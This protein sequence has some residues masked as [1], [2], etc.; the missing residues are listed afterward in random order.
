MVGRI[1][2]A[3]ALVGIV[4][5]L[6]AGNVLGLV[7]WAGIAAGVWWWPQWYAR[8]AFAKNP[9][10]YGPLEVTFSEQGFAA[11]TPHL[12]SQQDW[13]FFTSH[14]ESDSDFILIGS[15]NFFQAVPKRAFTDADIAATRSLLAAHVGPPGVRKRRSAL[16]RGIGIVV[17]ILVVVW[18][19]NLYQSATGTVRVPLAEVRAKQVVF[20]KDYE[21]G[22]DF[23]LVWNDGHP[24]ALS[25]DTK[26]PGDDA[27]FC[28]SSGMF[29]SPG[30]GNKFDRLGYYYQGGNS[31]GLDRYRVRIEGDDVLVDVRDR[32]PGPL[33]GAGDVQGPAGEFCYPEAAPI[34]SL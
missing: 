28:P 24:I 31:R 5:S 4:V 23:Y 7:F 2:A 9:Q 34:I 25:T 26:H 8:R 6:S 18:M 20:M 1:T 15:E 13:D 12:Q 21:D 32:Q 27:R 10:L 22:D 11:K 30:Y 3:V 19:I 14:E 17:G 29:E 33:R 16:K